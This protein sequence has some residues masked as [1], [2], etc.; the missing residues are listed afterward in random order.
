[1]INDGLILLAVGMVVV[2]LFL[3]LVTLLIKSMSFLLRDYAAREHK[4][5]L[6]AEAEKRR[7]KNAKKNKPSISAPAEDSGRL[8]AVI[9]AAVH[10][11]TSR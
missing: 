5:L 2:F 1:M 7:K 8:T 3:L 9:S 4:E 11:H 6:E 10:A